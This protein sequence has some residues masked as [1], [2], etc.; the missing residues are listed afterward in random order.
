MPAP[1]PSASGGS[2]QPYPRPDETIGLATGG[3]KDVSNFR[4]NVRNGYLPLPTDLS[5]EGLFYEYFFDTGALRP[6]NKLYAPS[7]SFAVTRDPFSRQTE[8]Y[9][10]VGLNSGMREE[11]FA[12]KTLNLAIVLDVSGSMSELYNQYYYDR[13]GVYQDAYEGERI[14]RP[15]KMDSAK[16]AVIRILNQLN[17]DD[18]FAIVLFNGSASLVKPMGLVRNIDMDD[19]IDKVYDINPGG[20]TNMSAG[21]EM[22][23]RQFRNFYE[24]DSYE[25]EN[26]IILLTDAQPNTGDTSSSGMMGIIEENADNQIYATVIGIGLD[27]NSDLI[28]QITRVKGANYYSIHSPRESRRL[29]GEEFEFM[30][31]PL[32]FNLRLDF[33]SRGWRIDE[34][35]GSPEADEATGRLMTIN[36]LFPSKREDGETK[37]GLVLLKLRKLSSST[38][39]EVF[40]RVSY[41]DRNGRED[42]SEEVVF[43]ER[44]TPE[45]F[46]NTG[47][48][49]G[50]L[51]TRYAALLKNW[52]I[53]ERQYAAYSQPWEPSVRE[54]TGIIIPQESGFSQ[55]ERQSLPLTVSN[56]YERLF[57]DF[58]EYFDDEMRDIG[59]FS[60]EQELDVLDILTR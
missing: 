3:A 38:D 33:E 50:I 57:T 1:A 2:S 47:I 49:K 42:E 20:N 24:I 23:T 44:E 54:D 45:F 10:S 9:L 34:V 4:Q 41:E 22:A 40:L 28:S 17:G 12:R 36:T 30:V 5:Y 6:T 37:G 43:L 39:D 14:A 8:Y 15:T 60:L 18:R 59:D 51:L 13:F 19:I 46:D 53:D 32:I 16:D 26:R 25:F 52:M 21:I 27:F 31:T 7:Y 48:Q 56:Q 35:F 29:M 11:D 55:W 58:A